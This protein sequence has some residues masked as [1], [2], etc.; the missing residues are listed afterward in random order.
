MKTFGPVIVHGAYMAEGS[1]LGPV[2]PKHSGP[3]TERAARR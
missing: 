1:A 2:G 3:Y